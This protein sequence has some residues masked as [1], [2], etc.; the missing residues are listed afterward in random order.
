MNW[1]SCSYTPPTQTLRFRFLY[2]TDST[3]KPI[4]GIVVTTSPICERA[5]LV[6]CIDRANSPSSP[7]GRGFSSS[8]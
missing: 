5:L 1:G 3:L 4:V 6:R 8:P 7:T 2:V